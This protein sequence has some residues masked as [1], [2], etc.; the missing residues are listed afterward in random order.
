MTFKKLRGVNLPYNQQGLIAFTC[1]TYSSQPEP[2]QR[3]IANLCKNVGGEEYSEALFMVMT[4]E[5]SIPRIAMTYY[6]SEPTL[7]RLRKKFYEQ[8]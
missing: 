8:W 6:V 3:K 5:M 1:R 7:Y 2:V 4:S